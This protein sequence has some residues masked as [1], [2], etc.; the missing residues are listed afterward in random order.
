LKETL[1][2]NRLLPTC[3]SCGL[4]VYFNPKV[5]AGVIIEDGEGTILIRRGI[6][7]AYGKWTFPGGYVNRGERPEDAAVREVAEEVGLNVSLTALHGIYSYTNH[8][9]IVI[10]YRGLIVDGTLNVSPECLDVRHVSPSAIPWDDLAFPST[11][12][13]LRAWGKL[14]S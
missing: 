8:P 3:P 9:I 11:A 2:E 10:V 14:S 6:E 7:P 4:I 13:A 5:A 12:E 1:V